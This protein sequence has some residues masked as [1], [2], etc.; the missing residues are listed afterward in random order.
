MRRYAFIITILGIIAL[1]A[2]LNLQKPIQ[3]SPE[4]DLR[5]LLQNQKVQLIGTVTEQTYSSIT[6]DN[7]LKLNCKSCPD[8]LNKKI[9]ILGIVETWTTIPRI[10]VLEIKT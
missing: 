1:I 2:L 4:T 5:D 7:N 3:I 6:L 9:E 8:Y 10:K